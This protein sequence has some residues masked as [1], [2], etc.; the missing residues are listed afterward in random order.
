MKTTKILGATILLTVFFSLSCK[1]QK[2]NTVNNNT[3]VTENKAPVSIT[4]ANNLFAI[5]L[6]KKICDKPENLF[7]APYSISTALAM[8]Y[9]GARENTEKQMG[10]IMHFPANSKDFYDKYN[11][12]LKEIGALNDGSAINIYNA[13]SIWAQR[14]FTFNEAFVKIL[15]NSFNSSVNTVDFINETEN[16]RQ[17]INTWVEK[18]TNEKIKGLIPSG[19]VD[20]LTRLVLVNA[21]YFK[22][23]WATAFDEKQTQKIDFHVEETS[24]VACDFMTAD[25]EFNYYEDETN[26]KAIEIPYSNGTLSMLIILPKDNAAF[27]ALKKDFNY[28]LYKKITIGLSPKK[29]KL[30]FPK[31]K[32]TSEFE[33]SWILKEMGMPDAFSDRA[34][35]SGMTGKKDLKISKVIHK[36]FVEV[37]ESGTEAAAATAVVMRIK[38]LP[39]N[40]PEFKADHPFMFIIKENKNNSILFT[41]NIHNPAE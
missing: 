34:D 24:S 26:L 15:K 37:N 3:S 2:N 31:F 19:L 25:K 21:I 23:N 12:S 10:E 11:E 27:V 1:T 8:T 32:I 9:V 29:V 6:Y 5:D 36:A 30:F 28:D 39:V 4:D 38:S 7:L 20:Y 41:G 16:S 18:Q 33:L 35:F 13:N 14:D 17:Q 22:A 40:Q